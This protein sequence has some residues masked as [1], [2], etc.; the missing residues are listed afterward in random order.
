MDW[1]HFLIAL[2]GSGI[3]MS[4]TDWFFFGV[5]FHDKYLVYPEVWR[6]QPG[7]P[8]TKNI[9]VVTL[10]GFITAAFFLI[11][12]QHSVHHGFQSAISLAVHIWGMV[13]V[14][15]IVSNALYV[16]FHPH[17]VISHSL[18]WL[19]KLLVVAIAAGW[20]LK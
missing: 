3:V 6:G 9:I 4:L 10:L 18:G 13:A 15:L 2:V 16:K 17:L 14:P 7:K 1:T 19:A 12:Y 5:L 11:T 20:L 8:E